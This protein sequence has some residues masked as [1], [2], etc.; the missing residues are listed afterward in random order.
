MTL[1]L[2]QKAYV[3]AEPLLNILTYCKFNVVDFIRRRKNHCFDVNKTN[4]SKQCDICHY[5]HFLNYSFKFQPNIC[6]KLLI[7]SMTVKGSD[8]RCIISLISKNAI[9]L[10]Q[11]ADL[12]E[13]SGTLKNIKI[14]FHVWK[15]ER[16][17]KGWLYWNWKK[18]NFTAIRFLSF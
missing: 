6:N 14:Y 10:M 7:I 8:Y 3:N 2:R 1:Q 4:A 13:K 5:S 11:N 18:L 12:T 9:N 15:W 17:F 16:N